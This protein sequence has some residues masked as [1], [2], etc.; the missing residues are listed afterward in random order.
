[1]PK[2]V[3]VPKDLPTLKKPVNTH[4]HPHRVDSEDLLQVAGSFPKN[5]YLDTEAEAGEHLDHQPMYDTFP[6]QYP[7]PK[8]ISGPSYQYP[9]GSYKNEDIPIFEVIY[10]N[11]I[12]ELN[13]IPDAGV[14]KSHRS[15]RQ[16]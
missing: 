12:I 16:L 15:D 2:L 3:K 5:V 10:L 8:Q 14:S 7:E 11:S 13:N 9:Q 1:M 4:N 6:Q